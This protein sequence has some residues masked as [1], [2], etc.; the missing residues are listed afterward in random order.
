[1]SRAY[2]TITG[3]KYYYGNEFFKPGMRVKLI[4]EKDNA[5]DKE[6]I[7]V[8]VKGLG[9]VGYVANSTYTVLGESMS[10]GRLYDKFG[11]KAVGRVMYVL[12]NGIL[13][14]LDNLKK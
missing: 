8:H 10:A 6:A 7:K 13:C 1:M 9:K 4:K 3:T 2:F 11:N 14:S 12:P 5:Y